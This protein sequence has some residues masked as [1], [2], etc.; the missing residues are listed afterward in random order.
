MITKGFPCLI[1]SD[2]T[3]IVASNYE[4]VHRNGTPNLHWYMNISANGLTTYSYGLS[5]KGIE[6]NVLQCNTRR[7]QNT[8]MGNGQT[9][10][11]VYAFRDALYLMSLSGRF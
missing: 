10:P 5:N 2:T 9:F 4:N 3:P 1:N 11:N 8:I 7:F 6:T